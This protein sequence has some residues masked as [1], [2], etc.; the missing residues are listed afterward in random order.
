MD[1]IEYNFYI[2]G[3]GF[4]PNTF[5]NLIPVALRVLIPNYVELLDPSNSLNSIELDRLVD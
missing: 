5:S 1:L 2:A 3:L 4:N